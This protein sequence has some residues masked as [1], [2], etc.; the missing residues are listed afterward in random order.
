MSTARDIVT[1][2]PR[3][4][5]LAAHGVIE[6]RGAEFLELLHRLSASDV[7]ALAEG[8]PVTALLVTDKGRVLDLAL[9]CRHE[10]A[11][12]VLTSPGRTSEVRAW[13]EKYTIMED[14]TYRDASDEWWQY[15]LTGAR[16]SSSA[17]TPLLG[18]WASPGSGRGR[19]LSL[20]Y[21]NATGEGTRVLVPAG[22]EVLAAEVAALG[23][24]LDDETFELLRIRAG[25]PAVGRELTG[26]VNPLEAGAAADVSFTKGCYIGQEVIARLDTYHKVQ[27]QLR[28]LVLVGT[29]PDDARAFARTLA[30]GTALTAAGGD[31]GFLTSCA[32]DPDARALIGLGCIRTAFAASGTILHLEGT[33]FD[34]RIE[35]AATS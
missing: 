26:R 3:V 21:A 33:A 10:D 11:T 12:L 8:T 35:D 2:A 31:G 1:D 4:R 23:A 22:D 13:F 17:T 25:L 6:A 29:M 15:D 32:Y 19:P 14:V 30:P 28:R 7:R 24:A 9:A 34:V 18:T 27:R 20:P 16:T 5:R